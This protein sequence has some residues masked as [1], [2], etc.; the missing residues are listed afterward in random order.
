M[1]AEEQSLTLGRE[2]K[3]GYSLTWEEW[4]ELCG[5][6]IQ[7]VVARQE[8]S[9]WGNWEYLMWGIFAQTSSKG[10]LLQNTEHTEGT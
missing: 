2:P 9:L 10:H 1:A 8:V 6:N 5:C 3:N 7:I 4:R